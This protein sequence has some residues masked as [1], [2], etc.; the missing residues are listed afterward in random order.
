[1]QPSGQQALLRRKN[2]L[3][4]GASEC[5]RRLN[6]D[7]S[8]PISFVKGRDLRSGLEQSFTRIFLV[9]GMEKVKWIRRSDNRRD[10]EKDIPQRR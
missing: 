1:M 10:A 8:D 6:F 2:R 5:R 3:T 4:C 7:H 9:L